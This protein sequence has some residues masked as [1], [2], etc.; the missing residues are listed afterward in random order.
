MAAPPIVP[1]KTGRLKSGYGEIH[2]K[3]CSYMAAVQV[4]AKQKR[5]P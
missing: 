3:I 1:S 2:P 4:E 5:N